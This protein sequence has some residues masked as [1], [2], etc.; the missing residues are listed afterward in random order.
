[1]IACSERPRPRFVAED[2][3]DFRL[4]TDKQDACL[5]AT[6]REFRILAHETVT[7]MNRV[8]SGRVR[9]RQYLF[10]IEVGCGAAAAQR[11][12]HI[13]PAHMQRTRIIFRIDRD[14]ADAQFGCR[15]RNA[16]RD[17][18]AIGNQ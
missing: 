1:M 7:G 14:R 10:D 13:G 8:A 17:L 5:R 6:A 16:N 18:A 2:L 3:Q 15:A 9:R 4:R 11:A 12:R